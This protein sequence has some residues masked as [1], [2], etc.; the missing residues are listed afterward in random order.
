MPRIFFLFLATLV[1]SGCSH[2]IIRKIGPLPPVTP[3]SIDVQEIDFDYLQ[4][5]TKLVFRDNTKEH[6]VKANIRIRKDSVIWMKL[7]V[8][9]IQGGAVLINK[10]SITIVSDLKNEYYVYTYAELSKRF[11]FKINYNIV[12]AALLGNLII[13]KRVTDNM[14]EDSFFNKLIQK[15]DSIT[16]QNLI[17]KST[18]KLER[19]DLLEPGT[20]NSIKINYSEFQPLGDKLFPYRGLIDVLYKS[21]SS[22]V[23]NTT[24]VFEYS[25]VDLGT[26][27]LRFHFKIPKRYDR[28]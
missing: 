9:G 15:E 1:I 8:L 20:G 27:E 17:N 4:G 6:E 23:V 3:K 16:I 24:I 22:G 25:K 28:R 14:G 21:R 2:R 13:P 18:K 11:N 12:Q 5:K 19:V 10:D 7:H 26:R